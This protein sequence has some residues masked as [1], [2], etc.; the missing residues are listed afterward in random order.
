ML[1][2]NSNKYSLPLLDLSVAD[3]EGTNVVV[4]LGP[5]VNI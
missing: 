4:G 2:N 3:T 1:N 5:V